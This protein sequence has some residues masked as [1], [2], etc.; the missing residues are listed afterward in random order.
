MHETTENLSKRVDIQ[1]ELDYLQFLPNDY[2]P[3][4]IEGYPLLLFLHGGG[5][6]GNDLELLK[7]TGLPKHLLEGMDIPMVTICPQCPAGELWD[8]LSLITLL[9]QVTASLNIDTC[10]VYLSGLSLGGRGTWGLANTHPGRF[11][12]IAPICA[13]F[14]LVNT[15]NFKSLPMWCF[16]GAMDSIVPIAD[17][18]RMLRMLRNAGCEV[19]F[20][21][22]PDA[23]HDSWTETYLNPQLYD[24]FLAQRRTSN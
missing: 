12:A 1:V 10:R 14:V 22:Y 24:W 19:K 5:E 2:D 8:N 23:D 9:D 13:P 20:T 15:D 21:V 4:R 16:H 18:V 17:S 6:R 11:A 7:S 3:G